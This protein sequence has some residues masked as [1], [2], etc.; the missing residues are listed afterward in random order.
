MAKRNDTAT[1][2][3]DV[4]VY[5]VL[6]KASLTYGPK[7]EYTVNATELPDKTLIRLLE[8]GFTQMLSDV[9]ALST[10]QKVRIIGK[11]NGTTYGK[12]NPVPKGKAAEAIIETK[13][14]EAILADHVNAKRREK[15][16]AMLDGTLGEGGGSRLDPIARRMRDIAEARIRKAAK[17]KRTDLTDEQFEK[18]VEN[19]LTRDEATLRAQAEAELRN[20]TDG[21]DE[22]ELDLA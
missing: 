17:D 19:L 8:N 11:A 4:T 7:G 2:T 21:A 3:L 10:E 1:A 22:I 20:R 15:L 9:G 6:S 16:K 13:A 5:P 18:N 14:A 12:D